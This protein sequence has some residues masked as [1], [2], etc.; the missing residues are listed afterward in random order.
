MFSFGSR[1]NITSKWRVV[2]CMPKFCRVL[3]VKQADSKQHVTVAR[4]NNVPD[5]RV[6]FA[7]DL[8]YAWW[9]L[10]KS[11]FRDATP[12][13]VVNKYQYFRG[14][15]YLHRMLHSITSLF[16]FLLQNIFWNPFCTLLGYGLHHQTVVKFP[17]LATDFSLIQSVIASGIHPAHL[18]SAN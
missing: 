2:H 5:E 7:R 3:R 15:C 10:S 18:I 9:F 11:Y 4:Q 17:A 14:N 1:T 8:W 6:S 13:S 16:C 12:C